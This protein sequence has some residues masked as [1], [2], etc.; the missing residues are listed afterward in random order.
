MRGWI[1]PGGGKRT[2]VRGPKSISFASR[3]IGSQG[4][5][6]RGVESHGH[7]HQRDPGAAPDPRGLAP[8]SGEGWGSA[9][10]DHHGGPARGRVRRFGDGHDS[11]RDRWRPNDFERGRRASGDEEHRLRLYEADDKGRTNGDLGESGFRAA[12]RGRE[13]RRIQEQSLRR[14]RHLQL[15]IHE[16]R[17]LSVQLQYP[18]ALMRHPVTRGSLRPASCD[19]RSTRPS[20]R[21]PAR[22]A[23]ATAAPRRRTCSGPGTPT[24]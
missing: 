13:Q 2:A 3:P 4:G 20:C 17:H 6:E 1:R 8:E 12:R 7:W 11:P 21:S 18:P 14:R 5:D 15:H 10:G 16:G 9:R 23:A 22:P 24:G 19:T